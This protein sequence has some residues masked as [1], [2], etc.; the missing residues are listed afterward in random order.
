MLDHLVSGARVA[1]SHIS[2]DSC[3]HPW[4]DI[5]LCQQCLCSSHPVVLGS[6]GAVVLLQD[7]QDEG[8]GCG[9]NADEALRVKEPAL[10]R[11]LDS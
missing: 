5:I 3:G 7:M 9:W 1:A 6:R 4:P 8:C 2:V 11:V 10:E